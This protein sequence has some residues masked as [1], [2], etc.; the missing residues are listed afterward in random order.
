MSYLI[1]IVE[2]K[3]NTKY[4]CLYVKMWVEVYLIN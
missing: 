2:V 4:I 3:T 1:S